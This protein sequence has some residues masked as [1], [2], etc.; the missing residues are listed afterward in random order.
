[1][2]QTLALPVALNQ[3]PLSQRLSR[4]RA[5]DAQLPCGAQLSLCLREA[6]GRFAVTVADIVAYFSSGYEVLQVATERLADGIE[7]RIVLRKLRP[8]DP[9]AIARKLFTFLASE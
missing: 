2:T 9:Q 7:H 1:M 3:L 8:L 4:I 5:V 6:N